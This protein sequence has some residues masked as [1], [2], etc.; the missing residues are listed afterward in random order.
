MDNKKTSRGGGFT[1]RVTNV[2]RFPKTGL[3]V[4]MHSAWMVFHRHYQRLKTG[5]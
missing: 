5:R 2:F 4:G 1:K 3:F